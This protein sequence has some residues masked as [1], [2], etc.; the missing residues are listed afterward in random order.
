MIFIIKKIY[1]WFCKGLNVFNVGL[2]LNLSSFV[3]DVILGIEITSLNSVE[4]FERE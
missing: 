3:V 4:Q 2:K 1:L